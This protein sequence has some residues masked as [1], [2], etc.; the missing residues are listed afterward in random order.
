MTDSRCGIN[1]ARTVSKNYLLPEYGVGYVAKCNIQF[2]SVSLFGLLNDSREAG[3]V[4]MAHN[5]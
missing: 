3:L 2:K 4:C 1:G 5:W